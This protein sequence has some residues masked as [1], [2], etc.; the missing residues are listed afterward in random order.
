MQNTSGGICTECSLDSTCITPQAQHAMC[1]VQ[2]VRAAHLRCS[3]G[4]GLHLKADPGGVG[5]C[6]AEAVAQINQL[7]PHSATVCNNSLGWYRLLVPLACLSLSG[8]ISLVQQQP[9][10]YPFLYPVHIPLFQLRS[11][12]NRKALDIPANLLCSAL[13]LLLGML[14]RGPSEGSWLLQGACSI[15]Q[16]LLRYS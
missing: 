11:L 3:E 4:Q 8:M 14:E 12:A 9:C 16:W 10:W 7:H 13:Y 2:K 15:Q 1:A 6:H 5:A